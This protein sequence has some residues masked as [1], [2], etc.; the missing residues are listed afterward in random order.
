MIYDQGDADACAPFPSLR[1]RFWG[2]WI[3]GDVLVVSVSCYK[4]D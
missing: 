4:E 3:S 1:R 2:I